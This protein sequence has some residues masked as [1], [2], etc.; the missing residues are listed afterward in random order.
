MLQ[1][2]QVNGY[3]LLYHLGSGD[4]YILITA[5]QKFGPCSTGFNISAKLQ[6]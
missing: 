2:V 5:A 3:D 1:L 6:T 4:R